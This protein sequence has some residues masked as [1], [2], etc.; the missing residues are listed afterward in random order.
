MGMFN[1]ILQ[2]IQIFVSLATFTD[3]TLIGLGAQLL[4][5]FSDN[6]TMTMLIMVL[7]TIWVLVSLIT[8]LNWAL[9]WFINIGL[10]GYKG[11][12]L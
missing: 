12:V 11:K 3:G 9:V 5:L 6:V 4:T 2:P 10:I 7:E 1:M 8:S